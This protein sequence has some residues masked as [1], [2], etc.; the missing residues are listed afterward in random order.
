MYGHLECELLKVRALVSLRDYSWCIDLEH[1]INLRV[2]E[3]SRG[4]IDPR[5]VD[6]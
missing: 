6:N 3:L 1:I 4:E 5:R 2:V